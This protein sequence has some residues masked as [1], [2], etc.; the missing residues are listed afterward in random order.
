MPKNS[1]LL[2]HPAISQPVG[3][4]FTILSSVESTNNYAMRQVQEG[5][6]SHGAA[7]FALEQTAGKGQ[8]GKQWSSSP[9]MNIII[10]I[11]L[12]PGSLQAHQQFLLSATVALACYDFFAKY[13]GSET[14]V[15]WPN[16]LYWRD[17]KAGGILIENNFYGSQWQYAIAGIGINI[18]QTNFGDH[19]PNAVSLGQIT[20]LHYDPARL[21]RELCSA[22]EIRYRELQKEDHISI[23][24]NYRQVMYKRDCSVKLKKENA[25]FETT[26]RGITEDGRLL[27]ED[28]L[29]RTFEFGEVEW[30]I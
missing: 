14:S 12:E 10:S 6:A 3:Q 22:L 30:L 5:M 1:N 27:T 9:N 18:N 17:R 19:L 28:V 21:A 2:P 24:S 15:K 25:V 29:E 13:A 7:W 8:R 11:V 4:P 16:D 26:V 20:G 23:I